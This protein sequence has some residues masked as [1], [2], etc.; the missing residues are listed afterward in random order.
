M[1]SVLIVEDDADTAEIIGAFLTQ[2][3][4][5]VRVAVNHDEALTALKQEAPD[6]ILMDYN[7]PHTPPAPFVSRVAREY[8]AST[9]ILMTASTSIRTHAAEL[10]INHWLGKPFEPDELIR[11]LKQIRAGTRTQS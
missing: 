3:N 8:P 11:M 1:P 9:L 4:Y 10:G 5:G 6:F 2:E 7:L